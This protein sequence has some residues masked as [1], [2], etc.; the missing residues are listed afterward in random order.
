MPIKLRHDVT[1]GRPTM[2]ASQV[3]AEKDSGPPEVPVPHD[4]SPTTAAPFPFLSIPRQGWLHYAVDWRWLVA[5]HIVAGGVR[6]PTLDRLSRDVDIQDAI[7]FLSLGTNTPASISSTVPS[8][9]EPVREV[10][11]L[12]ESRGFSR[13][14][15]QAL[16]GS[17]L[18]AFCRRVSSGRT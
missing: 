10:R 16:R 8:A 17:L 7:A 11:I 1:E 6:F 12:P 14:L 15:A 13:L 2:A 9:L 3:A 4:S 18:V 5:K